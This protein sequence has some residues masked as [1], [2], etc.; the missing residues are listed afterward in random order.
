M[1][2]GFIGF[3]HG[4][5]MG[6]YNAVKTHPKVRLAGAVEEDGETTAK[7]AAEGKVALTHATLREMLEK[8]ECD[9][10][11]VGDYFA[12]RGAVILAALAAGKHVIAD[13]PICTRLEELERIGALAKQKNLKIGCLLDL[14]DC[15]VFRTTRKLIRG[16]E[17]GDVL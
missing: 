13:K 11:A 3:R 8:T 7:L 14:L 16:G 1:R 6:L 15:G 10:I 17:I 4:H 9:A 5:I 2:I 12:K